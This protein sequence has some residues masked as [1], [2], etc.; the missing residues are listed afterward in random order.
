MEKK[1]EI[2]EGDISDF[3]NVEGELPEVIK[4]NWADAGIKIGQTPSLFKPDNRMEL[5]SA[6]MRSAN[7]SNPPKDLAGGEFFSFVRS[8]LDESNSKD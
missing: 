1:S 5:L 6:A 3:F 2:K 4:I 8:N 7:R